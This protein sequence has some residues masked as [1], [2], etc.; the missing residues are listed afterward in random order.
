MTPELRLEIMMTCLILNT[1][2]VGLNEE[3]KIKT[4]GMV[5]I[6]M[7]FSVINILKWTKNKKWGINR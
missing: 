3:K 2:H 7:N 5:Y 1:L 4:T 6:S